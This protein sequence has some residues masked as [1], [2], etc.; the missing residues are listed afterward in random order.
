MAPVTIPAA[1]ATRLHRDADAARWAVSL[2]RFCDV[3]CTSAEKGLGARANSTRDLEAF[4]TGLHLR[5]LALACACL[6]GNEAAWEQLVHDHRAPLQRAAEA[7]RPGGGRDL[8]DALYAELFGVSGS[9]RAKTS[10]LR[11]FHGRSSLGTWLRAVLAQRHIDAIRVER[12]LEPLPDA[13]AG[14]SGTDDDPSP[15]AMPA[16]GDAN[17]TGAASPERTRWVAAVHRAMTA[18][19]AALEPKDRLRLGLY[20]AESLTLAEIGRGLSEHE[21]TVSRNLTRTRK[22]LREATERYLRE[23]ETMSQSEI[24]ECLASV[25][26]DAGTLDLAALINAPPRRAG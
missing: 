11:Y 22:L 14:T 17:I 21:A 8:A 24:A 6:D 25:M 1:L 3:L 16:S 2:A 20:Y 5:D 9:G 13:I 7:L 18:A 23:V 19:I 4:L 12:R 26:A 10:L 15:R